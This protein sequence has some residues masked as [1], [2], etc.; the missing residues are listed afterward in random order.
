[1]RKLLLLL[2]VWLGF[3]ATTHAQVHEVTGRVTDTAGT[4]M[5]F[6]S[7]QV[8]GSKVTAVA[9]GEGKFAIRASSGDILIIT[10]SGMGRQEVRV[11]AAGTG[12]LVKVIPQM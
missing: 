2:C 5:P 9:D 1:M 3:V 10:S 6:A 8:K 12:I 7:V 4:P 11:G